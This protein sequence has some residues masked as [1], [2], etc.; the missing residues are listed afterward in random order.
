[1]L[2]EVNAV[3]SANA[4]VPIDVIL[5]GIVTETKLVHVLNVSVSI[6]VIPLP[7]LIDVK[8]VQFLNIPVPIL[9]T[10]SGILIEVK[11]EQPEKAFDFIN[12]IPIFNNNA[13]VA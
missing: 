2:T 1:M 12:E 4:L 6:N 9:V 3:Q 11:L 7:K 5:S 13:S 10:L 8:S